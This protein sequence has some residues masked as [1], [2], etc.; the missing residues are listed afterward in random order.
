VW[1]G[2]GGGQSITEHE[3]VKNT[4]EEAK[5]SQDTSSPVS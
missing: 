3:A 5:L 4:F 2:W 1:V